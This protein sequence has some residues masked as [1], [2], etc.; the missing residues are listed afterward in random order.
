LTRSVVA[1]WL[2]IKQWNIEGQCQGVL[3]QTYVAFCAASVI[4]IPFPYILLMWAFLCTTIALVAINVVVEGQKTLK[5][6][7]TM[8]EFYVNVDLTCVYGVVCFYYMFFV[9][10]F[11]RTEDVTTRVVRMTTMPINLCRVVIGT[12]VT[13]YY[14][15]TKM[16]PGNNCDRDDVSQD[17]YKN[18]ILLSMFTF[19]FTLHPC[20]LHFWHS[21][22]T[23]V[24][25]IALTQYRGCDNSHLWYFVA[26]DVCITITINALFYSIEVSVRFANL[27]PQTPQEHAKFVAGHA[28]GIPVALARCVCGYLQCI[29]DWGWRGP[30][31]GCAGRSYDGLGAYKAYV[32]CAILSF[33][34]VV[35][36]RFFGLYNMGLAVLGIITLLYFEGCGRWRLFVEVDMFA[37]I[38]GAGLSYFVWVFVL[39]HPAVQEAAK[40]IDYSTYTGSRRDVVNRHDADGRIGTAGVFR[41]GGDPS[42]SPEYEQ[43]YGS[44][45]EL[46][47]RGSR[48]GRGKGSPSRGRSGTV[49][50]DMLP[51]RR[52]SIESR[53]PIADQTDGAYDKGVDE[54]EYIPSS[55]FD[56]R[57]EGFT[58]KTGPRGLGYY[59]DHHV[60]LDVFGG[61]EEEARNAVRQDPVTSDRLEGILSRSRGGGDRDGGDGGGRR[62]SDAHA[63]IHG[64]GE[65][66]RQRRPS[67]ASSATNRRLD[68]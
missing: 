12:L 5:C 1:I 20:L 7:D 49:D 68:I 10:A 58:F 43:H 44:D 50:G 16:Q 26:I 24:G 35:S 42:D 22:K 57:K 31:D 27:R 13:L 67:G 51:T 39:D 21:F 11:R 59:S 38:G 56:G 62:Y 66:A 63:Y 34:P 30:P 6:R 60:A 19:I 28:I 64:G 47:A 33:I 9:S 53:V 48:R 18:Y 40:P 23:I 25:L 65:G 2:M 45:R 4:L 55:H 15:K 61:E 54:G 29:S 41:E 17:W 8:W 32:V 3:F 46:R 52:S 37:C 36:T 14:Y